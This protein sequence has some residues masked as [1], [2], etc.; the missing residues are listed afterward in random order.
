MFEVVVKGRTFGHPMFIGWTINNQKANLVAKR[1]YGIEEF[2]Y[3]ERIVH[4]GQDDCSIGMHMY[5]NEC[6]KGKLS[7][8]KSRSNVSKSRF[9]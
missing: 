7:I 1:L 5:K 9:C 8:L 4:V 3:L 6:T 2:Q